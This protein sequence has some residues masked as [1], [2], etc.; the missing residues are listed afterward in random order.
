MQLNHG[1]D[2]TSPPLLAP[3]GVHELL[4]LPVAEVDVIAAASP[5]PLAVRGHVSGVV[6]TGA[7]QQ[8]PQTTGLCDGV[9]HTCRCDGVQK[10]SL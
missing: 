9:H 6:V 1:R 10:G 7:L 4:G 3:P 2:V 8:F 5:F